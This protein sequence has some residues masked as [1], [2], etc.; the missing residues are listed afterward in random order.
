MP[1]AN[2]NFS[3]ESYEAPVGM[4]ESTIVF[5]SLLAIWQVLTDLFKLE[6][7]LLNSQVLQA[8]GQNF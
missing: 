1:K 2:E 5:G 7:P 3:F 6:E 4:R 8:T